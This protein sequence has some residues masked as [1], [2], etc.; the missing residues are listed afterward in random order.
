M[1]FRDI[2]AHLDVMPRNVAYI[3]KKLDAEKRAAVPA[4]RVA[5][6]AADA[7]DVASLPHGVA[8][9]MRPANAPAS[10]K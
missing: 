5:A 9:E 8:R 7:L 2:E 10:R 1:T 3:L 4:E 6:K